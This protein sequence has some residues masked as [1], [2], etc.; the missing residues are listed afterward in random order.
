MD[1]LENRLRGMTLAEPPLGFDPDEVAETA[2]KKV[3]NRRGVF[4]TGAATLAVL[5]VA[6][7]V[8]APEDEPAPVSPAAPPLTRSEQKAWDLRHLKEVLPGVL[9][10]AKDVSV[11]DFEQVNDWDLMTSEVKYTDAAGVKRQ[12]NL[13]ISGP[14]STKDGYPREGY[15]SPGRRS[16]GT[17]AMRCEEL[18]TPEGVPVVIYEGTNKMSE[19]GRQATSRNAIAWPSAGGSVNV[20]DLGSGDSPEAEP[21]LTDE[22]L[23]KLV[24]DP[25]FSFR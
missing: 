20:L 19:S 24:A 9:A 12:I 16:S 6:V 23:I 21:A 8:I 10:G 1:E 3:R 11:A 5:V 2:A 22:Q 15:C 13:T 14:V 4:A 17:E 18:V 7:V 25:A